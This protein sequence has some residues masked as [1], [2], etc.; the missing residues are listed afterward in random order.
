MQPAT[1]NAEHAAHVLPHVRHS[2]NLKFRPIRHRFFTQWSF[3][4]H[5]FRH[6]KILALIGLVVALLGIAGCGPGGNVWRT[7]GNLVVAP[8][9]AVE[10]RR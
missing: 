9:R 1:C 7:D 8:A 4:M 3:V 2:L 5:S 10:A 6:I